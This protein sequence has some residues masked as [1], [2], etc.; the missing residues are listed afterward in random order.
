MAGGVGGWL[1]SLWSRP[2]SASATWRRVEPMTDEAFLHA[3]ADSPAEELLDY[4][5][6]D[7]RAV[8]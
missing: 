2:R 5:D 7:S 3:I 6:L 4:F 8:R 1:Q